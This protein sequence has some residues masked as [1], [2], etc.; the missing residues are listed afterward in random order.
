MGKLVKQLELDALAFS[1]PSPSTYPYSNFQP[2]YNVSFFKVS[3]RSLTSLQQLSYPLATSNSLRLSK[4]SWTHIP[5]FSYLT[6]MTPLFYRK[7]LQKI[8]LCP[9]PKS[10]RLER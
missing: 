3:S 9:Y 2:M 7:Q 5:A 10:K 4:T 8:D 1:R 6:P